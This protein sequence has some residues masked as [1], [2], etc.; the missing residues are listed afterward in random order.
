MAKTIKHVVMDV[1]TRTAT[2]PATHDRMGGNV[3]AD[4]HRF[5]AP[6]PYSVYPARGRRKLY[7][8]ARHIILPTRSS[9]QPVGGSRCKAEP[10]Q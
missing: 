2:I 3:G 7:S 6:I 8:A 10:S 1:I 9:T 5:Q 4:E